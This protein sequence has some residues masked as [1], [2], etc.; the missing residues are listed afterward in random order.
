MHDRLMTYAELAEFLGKSEE[1]AR[2][3]AKRRR[4]RRSISN[5]DGKARVSV[6]VEFL[7]MPRP[8]VEPRADEEL[9]PE[10][11]ADDHPDTLTVMT[12]LQGQIAR[13][14]G[15]LDKARSALDAERVLSAQVEVLKAVLEAERNRMEDLKASEARRVEDLIRERDRWEA[16]ADE[17]LK[18]LIERTAVVPR[19]SALPSWWP[20]KRSA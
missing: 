17:T 5:D 12:I 16:K 10:Q 1:A 3:F 9:D 8:P 4:W 19:S 13:L 11:P 14:E 2:Q 18:A 20:W 6:P 7:D 15:E